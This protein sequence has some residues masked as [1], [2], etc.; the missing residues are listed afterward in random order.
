[1]INGA[2]FGP[3]YIQ[4]TLNMLILGNSMRIYLAKDHF[5]KLNGYGEAVA[6][7]PEWRSNQ[8]VMLNDDLVDEEERGFGM[9]TSATDSHRR[10]KKE[11]VFIILFS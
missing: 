2:F 4:E 8:N 5:R 6:L 9:C 3:M 1:M 10:T 11:L 7:A